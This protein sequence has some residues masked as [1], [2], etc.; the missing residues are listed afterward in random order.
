MYGRLIWELVRDGRTPPARKALL[1][2]A[3][4]YFVLGRD[5]IPDDIPIV[6]GIDDLIVVILAVELFLDGV[7]EELL[8]EKLEAL[9]IDRDA[10]DRDISRIRRLTPRPVRRFVRRLPDLIDDAAALAADAGF[11]RSPGRRAK[12][13]PLA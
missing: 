11:G 10:F 4:G 12:E 2:G 3:A 8:D 5:L 9:G 7:P 13:G 1:A 6:G